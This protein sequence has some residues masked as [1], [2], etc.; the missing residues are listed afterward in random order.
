[1]RSKIIGIVR[2]DY[3]PF[4]NCQLSL[5][6]AQLCQ[7]HGYFAVID[8]KFDLIGNLMPKGQPI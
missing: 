1:M 8:I 6:N 3:T 7:M 5:G 2:P 4:Y